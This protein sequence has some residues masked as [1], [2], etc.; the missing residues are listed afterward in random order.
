MRWSDIP[1]VDQEVWL[2]LFRN[3]CDDNPFRIAGA[4]TTPLT[5][6]DVLDAIRAEFGEGAADSVH[7]PVH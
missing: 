3:L 1:A 7:L 2:L 5:R 6:A 4:T